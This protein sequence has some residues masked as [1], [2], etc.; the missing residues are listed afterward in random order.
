MWEKN[1]L[2]SKKMMKLKKIL[3]NMDLTMLISHLLTVKK[4]FT[5]CY[6]E[7]IFL[8]KNKKIRQ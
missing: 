3:Q 4:T 8:F 6:I 2:V 7:N 1:Y 5:S